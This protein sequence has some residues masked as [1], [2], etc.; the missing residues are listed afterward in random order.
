MPKLPL[1]VSDKMKNKVVTYVKTYEEPLI[2]ENGNLM[3]KISSTDDKKALPDG[4]ND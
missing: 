4:D 3:V 2:D 1:S